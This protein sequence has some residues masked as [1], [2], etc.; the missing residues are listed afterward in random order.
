LLLDEGADPPVRNMNDMIVLEITKKQDLKEIIL[1]LENDQKIINEKTAKNRIDE[2]SV[3]F[4][5][6]QASL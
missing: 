3:L 1:I 4:F 2:T 6:L 5:I